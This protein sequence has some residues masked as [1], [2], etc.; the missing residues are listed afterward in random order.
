MGEEERKAD[1]VMC[2]QSASFFGG[3]QV[4]GPPVSP[5]ETINPYESGGW[6]QYYVMA[7]CVKNHTS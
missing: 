2:F 5:K 6:L 7:E 4:K 3:K 1:R